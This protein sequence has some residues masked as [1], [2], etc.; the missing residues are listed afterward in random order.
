MKQRLVLLVL[1]LQVPLQLP[2]VIMVTMM[3][4]MMMWIRGPLVKEMYAHLLGSLSVILLAPTCH[5]MFIN[6]VLS[7]PSMD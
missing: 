1:D 7:T 2:M 5:H 4:M 3:I 6:V